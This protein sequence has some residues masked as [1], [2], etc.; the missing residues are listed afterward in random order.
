MPIKGSTVDTLS[1]VV[2]WASYAYDVRNFANL[3]TFE[4]THNGDPQEQDAVTIAI[5]SIM[6][7]AYPRRGEIF[8]MQ[9]QCRE[10]YEFYETF[11][12]DIQFASMKLRELIGYRP[13][14]VHDGF[15]TAEPNFIETLDDV[16]FYDGSCAWRIPIFA[17]SP[18][19]L[20]IL[21][22]LG[23][24]YPDKNNGFSGCITVIGKEITTTD[25]RLEPAFPHNVQYFRARTRDVI[26]QN[27][28]EALVSAITG[29]ADGDGVLGFDFEMGSEDGKR[30]LNNKITHLMAVL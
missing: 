8:A 5:E 4:E 6:T 19:C 2:Q 1:S 20:S 10:E 17:Y 30:Y 26:Y 13:P 12:P 22:I 23:F 11:E 9:C 16:A 28:T 14:V 21:S 24:A 27:I 15:K 18:R 7:A 3:A 25:I 29:L